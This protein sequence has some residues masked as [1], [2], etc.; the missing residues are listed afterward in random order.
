MVEFDTRKY[1]DV[2]GELKKKGIDTDSD[3]VG[4]SIVTIPSKNDMLEDFVKILKD[5]LADINIFKLGFSEKFNNFDDSLLATCGDMPVL[6][7][8]NE[9]V[10]PRYLIANRF[11]HHYHIG[12]SALNGRRSQE[13]KD[14]ASSFI[15]YKSLLNYEQLRNEGGMDRRAGGKLKNVF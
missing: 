14:I 3:F 1:E 12:R 8:N 9:G 5:F 2:I 15:A 7:K 10:K 6:K 13:Y 11:R 4:D